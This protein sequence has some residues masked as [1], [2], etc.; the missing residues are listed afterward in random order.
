MEK[1]YLRADGTPVWAQVN[2]ALLRD[3]VG[4]PL[5]RMTQWVDVSDRKEHEQHLRE[6]A[7]AERAVAEELRRLDDI[8]NNFLDAVSHELRT[9]LTVICG[10]GD[11]LQQRRTQLEAADRI[12]LEDA[13]VGQA[14]RLSE[15]LEGLM[16]LKRPANGQGLPETEPVDVVTTIR[17]VVEASPVAD[18]VLLSAPDELV[19]RTDRQRLALIVRN[20]LSNIAKY[21]P[22]GPVMVRITPLEGGG[23]RLDVIDDGPGIPAGEREAVFKPFHRSAFHH[24]APGTGIGLSLVARFADLHGGQA[25]VED[26]DTGAHLAV[27]LPDPPPPP[28]PPATRAGT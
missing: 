3:A 11:T 13:I 19:M 28:A 2:I 23:L 21:A 18:R 22:D 17:H 16:E 8:K 5:F 27:T 4:T 26:T 25:W 15:L 14:H 1:R 10:I 6:V 20:L 7:A 24:P 9:P 12:R